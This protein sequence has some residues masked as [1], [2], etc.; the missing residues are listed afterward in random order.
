MAAARGRVEAR[1]LLPPELAELDS[2]LSEL[3][4][5]AGPGLDGAVE[6][7]LEAYRLVG[8]AVEEGLGGV[9]GPLVVMFSGGKDSLVALDLAHRALGPGRYVAAYIEIPGNTHEENIRYA[10]RVA[11]LYGLEPGRGFLHLRSVRHSFYE[12]VERWGWPGPRRRW[13]MTTF[14]TQVVNRHLPGRV[15]ATGVKAGDSG[16]RRSWARAGVLGRIPGWKTIFFKPIIS[17]TTG[18]VMEYIRERRLPLNPLYETLGGSANCVYCPYNASPHYYRRLQALYPHWWRRLLEAEARVAG[19]KP[20]YQGRGRRLGF[21]DI[22][23]R[24]RPLEAPAASCP[25]G[26][27]AAGEVGV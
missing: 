12:L 20:F 8:R 26:G 14:K 9:R 13:C 18:M 15:T 17:W 4:A 22:A 6:A 7:S 2:R 10:Y 24:A 11:S 19:G 16:W 25:V 23:A 5:G 1:S 3:L 21:E 27:C